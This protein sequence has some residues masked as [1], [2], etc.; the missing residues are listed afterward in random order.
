MQNTVSAF[1]FFGTNCMKKKEVKHT[2]W[3]KIE[4]LNS[5]L[6]FA[7]ES[8]KNW[9]KTA[10]EKLKEKYDFLIAKELDQYSRI[11][12]KV[13]KLGHKFIYNSLVES[14]RNKII[15]ERGELKQQ[16]KEFLLPYCAWINDENLVALFNE[17]CYIAY[18]DGLVNFLN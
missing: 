14:N 2:Q 8:D 16:L 6:Y 3:N 11:F 10:E 1:G 7:L 13:I 4:I 18:K 15:I 12:N 9:S 17:S 5:G